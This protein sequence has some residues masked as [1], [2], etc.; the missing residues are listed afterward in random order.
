MQQSRQSVD[1]VRILTIRVSGEGESDLLYAGN[2]EMKVRESVCD[3]DATY[4]RH[5]ALL[6]EFP[7]LFTIPFEEFSNLTLSG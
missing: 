2:T 6:R 3:E 4:I 1:W 7:S 5:R